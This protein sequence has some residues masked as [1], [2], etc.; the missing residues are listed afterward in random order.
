MNRISRGVTGHRRHKKILKLAKGFRGAKS[1]TFRSAKAAVVRA[2]V[3]SYRDRKVRKRSMRALWI[4]RINA[5]LRSMHQTN[6][7][8]FMKLNQLASEFTTPLNRKV[9]A[10]LAVYDQVGFDAYVNHITKITQSAAHESI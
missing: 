2:H 9:L 6:Y 1:R 10:D 7:S 3:F 8:H 5:R 4:T